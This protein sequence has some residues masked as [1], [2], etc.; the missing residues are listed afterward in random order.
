MKEIFP[1]VIGISQNESQ[2]YIKRSFLNH[3]IRM[4][5]SV[6]SGGQNWISG[7]YNTS[8]THLI[9]T[10]KRFDSLT[11]WINSEVMEYAGQI[12]YNQ[13]KFACIDSWIN[14]YEKGD[15]QEIHEH[16]QDCTISAVYYLKT[17]EK[18]GNLILHSPEPLGVTDNF[19][20]DN[21]YTWKIYTIEPKEGMLVMFKANVYH[22]V[23]KNDAD[24]ERISIAYNFKVEDSIPKP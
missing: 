7:V 3:C 10:D 20:K 18:S 21:P 22:N 19:D 15:Y 1:T 11:K 2:P 6:P 4:K 23:T 24:E 16:T 8:G 13:K 12:G 17:P 9:H 5:E 14:F